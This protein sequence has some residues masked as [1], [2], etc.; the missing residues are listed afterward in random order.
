[1]L[2]VLA[3]ESLNADGILKGLGSFLAA[4]PLLTLILIIVLICLI[5]F[6]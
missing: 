2:D 1:M 5:K 3:A 4:N 6:R